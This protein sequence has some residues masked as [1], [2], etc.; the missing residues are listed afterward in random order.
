[1]WYVVCPSTSGATTGRRSSPR[2]FD[3]GWD[4]LASRRCTSSRV[5]P[6]LTGEQLVSEAAVER[7]RVAVLP[8]TARLRRGPMARDIGWSIIIGGRTVRWG[9]GRRRSLPPA[10]R[11]RASL[12]SAFSRPAEPL[13]STLYLFP[14][15]SSHNT[16]Y[17]KRGRPSRDRNADRKEKTGNPRSCRK[18][19]HGFRVQVKT[20]FTGLLRTYMPSS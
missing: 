6:L 12:R 13:E 18:N 11:L 1:M 5:L 16:W 4:T 19:R 3:V 7:L 8:R 14:K 10:V 20:N 17:K 15:P 2:R 9:I